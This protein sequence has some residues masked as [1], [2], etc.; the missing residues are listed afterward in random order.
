[1]YRVVVVDDERIMRVSVADF[2]RDNCPAFALSGVYA[3]GAQAL[4]AFT[5]GVPDVLITDIRMQTVSGLDLARSV[6]ERWPLCSVVVISGYSDFGY[7]KEAIRYGVLSYILK[8][9]D[10]TELSD[11]LK[12][13]ENRLDKQAAEANAQEN[14]TSENAALFLTC[15]LDGTLKTPD[16]II[17]AARN[18]A[19]PFSADRH[20]QIVE[21]TVDDGA[22]G[23]NHG[24]EALA[25]ALTNALRFRFAQT[26]I[27][28]LLRADWHYYFALAGCEEPPQWNAETVAAEIRE[29]L[30]VQCTLW[31]MHAPCRVLDLPHALGPDWGRIVMGDFPCAENKRMIVS[32]AVDSKDGDGLNKEMLVQKA[33]EYIQ[34]EYARDITRDDAARAIFV[35]PSYLSHIFKSVTGLSFIDYL[36]QVRMDKAIELIGSGARFNDIAERVGYR[37]RNTFLVNFRQYTSCTPTEY[38]NKVLKMRD[39]A[40][41]G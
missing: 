11:C 33:R 18:L 30:H 39:A 1:M 32:S 17:Q 2:I 15:A 7:A 23:W 36:T 27:Y 35:S 4:E 12:Q 26:G 19:V 38:R 31:P 24:K 34:K 29:L 9:I 6:R 21:L 14:F 37:S 5:Q 10:F 3:D 8:P 22:A 41:E 40:N 25:M 13:L 20:V 16:E 28:L